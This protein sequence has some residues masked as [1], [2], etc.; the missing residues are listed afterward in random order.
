MHLSAYGFFVSSGPAQLV[1]LF[2]FMY[3]LCCVLCMHNLGYS[4]SLNK[5]LSKSIN[6]AC[7]VLCVPS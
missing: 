2:C 1:L 5:D 6:S 7:M 4:V 3:I